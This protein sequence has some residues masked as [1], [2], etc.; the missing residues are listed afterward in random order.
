MFRKLNYADTNWAISWQNQQNDC[1]PGEDSD[2]PE[3]LLCAQWVAKGPRFLHADSK[4]SDRTGRMPRL[5]ESSLGAHSLCWFCHF[6]AQIFN[7]QRPW[8]KIRRWLESQVKSWK[9]VL[10]MNLS[11]NYGMRTSDQNRFNGIKNPETKF[12][13]TSTYH[14]WQ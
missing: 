3:S 10:W 8:I 12:T 14:H 4:D 7:Q 13:V 6:A 1:P 2:E 11:N 5:S 9:C